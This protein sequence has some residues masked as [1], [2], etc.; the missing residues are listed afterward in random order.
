MLELL[1]LL[2][3]IAAAYGWFMGRNS[4]RAEQ[5]KEQ[6]QFS[7]KYVTGI[8]LLL[9]DQSDKAVDLF[10]DILDVDSETLDTHWALGKLFRRRGEVERAIRIHQNLISRPSLADHDRHQA[11]FELGED[12]LSAGLYD[13]AENM[14]SD[15]QNQPRFREPSLYNLIAIYESTHEWHKAI[16]VALKISRTDKSVEPTV[17]QFYCEL[18]DLQEDAE[19]SLKYYEKALKH[20]RSC[21]RAALALGRWWLGQARYKKA[22]GYL[23]LVKDQDIDFVSEALPLIRDAYHAMGDTQSFA[24]YLHECLQ[25]YPSA[26]VVNMLADLIAEQNHVEEA[27]NFLTQA[28]AENPTAKGF[29]KLIQ[30]HVREAEQGRARESLVMLQKMV[31]ER[32]KLNAKYHCRHCGFA[33]QTLYWHCPSCKAWAAIKPSKGLDGE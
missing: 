25:I 28:L 5:R 14:F 15:L 32:L 22:L 1:F 10:V 9:S 27:E 11:L 8:N 4:V 26:S 30:L 7:Q 19:T 13:R 31:A 33:T 2:L 18:A 17:A 12:Y 6:E 24:A 21:V 3:P 16:K 23:T 20:D 29:H